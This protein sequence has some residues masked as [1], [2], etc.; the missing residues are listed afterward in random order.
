MSH[1]GFVLLGVFAWNALALQGAV[2]AMIAHGF[3]TGAL[4]VLVGALQERTE[5]R[6][7]DK[8]SGLWATIPFFSGVGLFLSLASMGLPSLADFIGE[9]LVLLGTFAEHP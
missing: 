1:L 8:L 2:V 3:S 4:F 9:F 5:T 6:E 7:M